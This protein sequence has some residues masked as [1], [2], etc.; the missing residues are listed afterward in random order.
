M[1]P[2]VFLWLNRQTGFRALQA[3]ASNAVRFCSLASVSVVQMECVDGD[4]LGVSPRP[5]TH[6]SNL[7]GVNEVFFLRTAFLSSRLHQH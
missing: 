7:I 3:L 6:I 4:Q 5:V 1:L 2:V